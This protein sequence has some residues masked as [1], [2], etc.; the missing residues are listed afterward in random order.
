MSNPQTITSANSVLTLAI[1]NL[2][3][4]PQQIQGFATD[5]MFDGGDVE[6]AEGKIGADGLAAYGFVFNLQ[7]LTIELLPN[8]PSRQIFE[9]WVNA[10]KAAREIYTCSGNIS[11]PAINTNITLVNGTLKSYP[12]FPAAKKVMDDVRYVLMFQDMQAEQTA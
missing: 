4:V 9:D 10:T 1:A 3:P 12:P 11:L 6:I 5:A 7:S 2:Y 8:S